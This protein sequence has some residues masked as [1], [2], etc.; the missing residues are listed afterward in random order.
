LLRE[1]YRVNKN[2]LAAAAESQKK[3][4]RILFTLTPGSYNT[5]EELDFKKVSVNMLDLI[6]RITGKLTK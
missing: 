5:Y 1:A 2:T 4:L 3:Y 6:Q